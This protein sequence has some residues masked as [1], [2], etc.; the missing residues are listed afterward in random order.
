M[1]ANLRIKW[2][3]RIKYTHNE[4]SLIRVVVVVVVLAVDGNGANDGDIPSQQVSTKSISF[5]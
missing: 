4:I 1:T 2:I 3:I 5:E